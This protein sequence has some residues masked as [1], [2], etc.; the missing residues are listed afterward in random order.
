MKHEQEIADGDSLMVATEPLSA[1]EKQDIQQMK[2]SKTIG[3]KIIE[4][5]QRRV[6][7]ILVKHAILL[8]RAET[9]AHPDEKREVGYLAEAIE[10][11]LAL[12]MLHVDQAKKL[13][14]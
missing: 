13:Y 12:A 14:K 11:D 8:K 9:C 2:S 1:L 10:E 6:A 7:K 4:L 3:D 5:L